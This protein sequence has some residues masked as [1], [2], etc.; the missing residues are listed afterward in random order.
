MHRQHLRDLQ[1]GD[2][3]MSTK[4]MESKLREYRELRRMADELAAEIEAVA[5]AIKQAMGDKEQLIVG[6]YKAMWKPVESSRIDTKALKAVM[7]DVAAQ[8]TKTS[9]VRRFQVN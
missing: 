8:F 4:E 3:I 7:P 9:T 6:E 5:D 1:E 2:T